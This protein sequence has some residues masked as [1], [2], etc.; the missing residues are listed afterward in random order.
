MKN[1]WIA[2][3]L[4][5]ELGHP[6]SVTVIG[7]G[8]TGSQVVNQLARINIAL[9]K[10]NRTGLSVK[11]FDDD[12]VS[13]ANIG[14]QM[15][16]EL[17]LGLPK[18]VSLVS[19]INRFYGFDWI[20]IPAQWNESTLV[21]SNFYISCVDNVDTR[22]K[23][24]EW[25]KEFF[26]KDRE[27]YLVSDLMPYYWMDFGNSKTSGQTVLGTTVAIKQPKGMGDTV[28]ELPTVI[29][30]FGDT[31]KES[32]EQDDTPSCS[33]AEALSKQDLFINSTLVQFGM[34][35]FWKLINDYCITYHGAFVNLERMNVR[36]IPVK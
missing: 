10:L 30:L 19:R 15:F 31:L 20:G 24:G 26:K 13:E 4:M 16:S 25:L 32:E 23:L 2:P 28:G 18:S 33:L 12:L 14:R 3:E 1:H 11:V 29:D 5:G 9:K 22:I 8:G 21:K 27:Q 36:G 7:A 6:I 35:I 17:D 34:N